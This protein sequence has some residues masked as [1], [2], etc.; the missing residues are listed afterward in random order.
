[1]VLIHL[2]LSPQ[3][4]SVPPSRKFVAT[5]LVSKVLP[6]RVFVSILLQCFLVR[7]HQHFGVIS[8]WCS[9]YH[10]VS[11]WQTAQVQFPGG[12]SISDFSSKNAS[13]YWIKNAGVRWTKTRIYNS[14]NKNAKIM[15]ASEGDILSIYSI[16]GHW[17]G[18]IQ[19]GIT[20]TSGATTKFW[21]GGGTDSC[22]SNP[23]TP[24][25]QF[26]S[27]FGHFILKILKKSKKIV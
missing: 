20:P 16:F 17:T 24:K 25:Y 26:S 23:P 12:E 27:D 1:M 4:E 22:L 13:D 14:P 18:L 15:K 10:T 5:P 9:N 8:L 7:N 21:L 19:V 2:N 6:V 3:S 11:F